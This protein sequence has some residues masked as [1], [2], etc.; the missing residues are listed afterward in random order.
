MTHAA[1]TTAL[2]RGGIVTHPGHLAAGKERFPAAIEDDRI[3]G[4]G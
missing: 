1:A 3:G 2:E 4:Q